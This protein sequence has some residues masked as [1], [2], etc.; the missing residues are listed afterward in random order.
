MLTPLPQV[1]QELE[2]GHGPLLGP[3]V[4]PAGGP[5]VALALVRQGGRAQAQDRLRRGGRLDCIDGRGAMPAS[6][7]KGSRMSVNRPLY[8]KHTPVMRGLHDYKEI[9]GD[10]FAKSLQSSCSGEICKQNRGRRG[11]WPRPGCV[12]VCS[13][14]AG[15][16]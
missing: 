9:F 16:P 7:A 1:V 8:S 12:T 2:P 14:V 4:L 10:D 11:G 13:G 6:A 5:D 15:G 3:V